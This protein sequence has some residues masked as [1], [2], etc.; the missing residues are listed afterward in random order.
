MKTELLSLMLALCCS[1]LVVCSVGAESSSFLRAREMKPA[2]PP[3]V[4]TH[5][6]FERSLQQDVDYT[7]HDHDNEDE[8]HTDEDQNYY[9]GDG[10]DLNGETLS[11][12]TV[13]SSS[14]SIANN[15]DKPWAKAIGFG[16]LI[17]VATLIGLF[18]LIPTLLAGAFCSKWREPNKEHTH[19]ILY[20][21]IPSFACGALLATTV[22]LIL[23]EA[24]LLM[25]AATG[26]MGHDG[27]HRR[28]SQQDENGETELAWK[29]GTSLLGGYLIPTVLGSIFPHAHV[30]DVPECPVCE[31]RNRE[32]AAVAVVVDKS[33]MSLGAGNTTRFCDQEG[34]C[35]LHSEHPKEE[36]GEE[37][38]IL[39]RDMIMLLLLSLIQ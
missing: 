36:E 4:S 20:T 37:G 2:S 22:F 16:L 13:S 24:L 8:D 3:V 35:S 34:C 23:P 14:S 6:V 11:T 10:H 5:L 17:N 15:T 33:E 31:E 39:Y 21:I 1:V 29:F 18:V 30:E 7:D 27:E 25:A 32:V 9:E 12:T 38:A 26:V 19:Y 28:V